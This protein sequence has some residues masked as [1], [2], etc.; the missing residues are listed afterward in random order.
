M[1]IEHT[2]AKIVS[3]TEGSEMDVV[4]SDLCSLIGAYL[5]LGQDDF[6]YT[7]FTQQMVTM[8]VLI[9]EACQSDAKWKK[10][11]INKEVGIRHKAL[12]DA[13]AAAPSEAVARALK[14]YPVG[15]NILLAAKAVGDRLS[16]HSGAIDKVGDLV[17]NWENSGVPLEIES[18]IKAHTN[19]WAE[20]IPQKLLEKSLTDVFTVFVDKMRMDGD[21]TIHDIEAL[22]WVVDRS[23]ELAQCVRVHALHGDATSVFLSAYEFARKSVTL[24]RKHLAASTSLE[25]IT[26]DDGREYLE[27]IA[28]VQALVKDM[29]PIMTQ[30][31]LNDLQSFV[32]MMEAML[33]MLH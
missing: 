18:L 9:G 1:Q 8:T 10:D 2:A 33:V 5:Q 13:L 21:A 16:K 4:S 11:I 30:Y 22:K 7:S 14:M 28:S 15:R 26:A 29:E 25:A 24:L 20:A 31:K 19:A 23:T 6:Q 12:K 3:V 17:A 32:V 27:E